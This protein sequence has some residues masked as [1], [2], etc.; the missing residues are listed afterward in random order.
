MKKILLV[1]FLSLLSTAFI[2]KHHHLTVTSCELNGSRDVFVKY[3][4][5]DKS[6][7][8]GRVSD[9][10]KAGHLYFSNKF[11]K[12]VDVSWTNTNGKN[13]IAS[14][15]F[16]D[17]LKKLVSKH[18]ND[19]YIVITS[20]ND[21]RFGYEIKEG[22]FRFLELIGENQKRREQRY[23]TQLLIKAA[24]DGNTQKVKELAGNLSATEINQHPIASPMTALG[25]SMRFAAEKK[26][27]EIIEYLLSKGAI[28][29]IEIMWAARDANM[30]ALK[31]FLNY[32][33]DL[34]YYRQDS[35]KYSPLIAAIDK[36]HI[37][38]VKWLI[39]NGADVNM[40]IYNNI[41]PIYSA[42]LNNEPEI[43]ELLLKNGAK[44]DVSLSGMNW[45]PKDA[46]EQ[47]TDKS[48]S[49]L[50]NR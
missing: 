19:L 40:P 16:P 45:T 25:A 13:V 20:A 21:W 4:K 36:G 2:N 27:Y 37:N 31:L 17:D 28:P 44:K 47:H 35:G 29:G 9:Q 22:N 42:A 38:I 26:N 6:F 5:P 18:G 23:S 48:S 1:T 11:P 3:H 43:I 49:N 14:K 12:S 7:G 46:A 34:N 33:A 15:V 39:E 30:T 32:G 8:F 50:L 41:T 10:G 24:R